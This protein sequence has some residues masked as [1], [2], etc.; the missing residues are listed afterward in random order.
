MYL[1]LQPFS[2][3][4]QHLAEECPNMLATNVV[5]MDYPNQKGKTPFSLLSAMT[6][7][8]KALFD[9]ENKLEPSKT[10]QSQ[11]SGLLPENPPKKTY[12]PKHTK[13]AESRIPF[14][15]TGL[16]HALLQMA[17]LQRDVP[18]AKI[19]D[20]A[21]VAAALRPAE[22]VWNEAVEDRHYLPQEI[23]A[24]PEGQ[25]LAAV[26]KLLQKIKSSHEYLKG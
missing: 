2:D 8:E 1:N 10:R 23:E 18:K 5:L 21:I 17:V 3:M 25:R 13:L 12:Q 20:E 9:L 16:E 11:I 14:P 7:S 6:V 4:A 26:L 22:C 24:L 19:P 15:E